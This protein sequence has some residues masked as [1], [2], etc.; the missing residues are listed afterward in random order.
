MMKRKISL[1]LFIG[2][3]IILISPLIVTASV[4]DMSF[5]KEENYKAQKFWSALNVTQVEEIGLEPVVSF[6]VNE[7]EYVLIATSNESVLV[8]DNNNIQIS[9][10]SFETYGSFF[11]K[12]YNQDVLLFLDRERT[13]V[14]MDIYGNLIS[15]MR[16]NRDDLDTAEKWRE[17]RK[18]KSVSIDNSEY[19]LES[20]NAFFTTATSLYSKIEKID[21]NGNIIDIYDAGDSY[22]GLVVLFYIF[23]ISVCGLFVYFIVRLFRTINIRQ[24]TVNAQECTGDGSVC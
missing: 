9:S 15:V 22:I 24:G 23:F 7:N 10:F 6:D 8:L 4:L 3:C 12:W 17:L 16:M 14:H 2:T 11:V 20:S 19:Y 5:S 13:V 21:N 18:E 1:S